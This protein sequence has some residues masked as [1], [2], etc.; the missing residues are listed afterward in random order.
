MWFYVVLFLGILLWLVLGSSKLIN[1]KQYI[2]I[3]L[4]ILALVIG[5][6]YQTGKDIATYEKMFDAIVHGAHYTN[7]QYGY[8]IEVTFYLLTKIVNFL[9][10][11]FQAL[12]LTYSLLS[13]GFIYKALLNLNLK[14][15]EFAMFVV[16]FC[17]YE[18]VNFFIIMRQFLAASIIFYVFSCKAD[19]K[20]KTIINILLLVFA[21]FVHSAAFIIIPVYLIFKL[22]F[23]NKTSFKV[24]FLIGAIWLGT[25]EYALSLIERI[26][27]YFKKYANYFTKY[28]FGETASVSIVLFVLLILFIVQIIVSKIQN[29]PLQIGGMQN[30]IL[31]TFLI[32]FSSLT[33]GL[34]N[35]AYWYTAISLCMIPIYLKRSIDKSDKRIGFVFSMGIFLCFSA[36]ALYYFMN[37]EVID[38]TMVPYMFKINI[39]E[40]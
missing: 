32:Y 33:L 39:F 19:N 1:K 34:F 18:F 27:G 11:N 6:R 4:L 30:A 38:P 9:H 15:S 12:V 29:E 36:Y 24:V 35:R 40:G 31:I 23:I 7:V 10:L 26:V 5:L 22:K 25:S 8:S 20:K 13:F 2:F 16:V 14:K 21:G 17:A 28:N 37:I 3:P